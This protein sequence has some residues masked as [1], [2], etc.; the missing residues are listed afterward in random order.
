MDQSGTPAGMKY[1]LAI[2]CSNPSTRG[3][4]RGEV[5]IAKIT[6]DGLDY[7]DSLELSEDARGSDGLMG[8]V[9]VLCL[10]HEIVPTDIAR[11]VVSVGPGGYTALRVSVTVAKVLAT[12]VGCG[13]VA[14]PS[15]AVAGVGLE[16]L[17]A[18]VALASKKGLAHCT[19]IVDGQRTVLGV[20]GADELVGVGAK[21]LVGDGFV[22]KDMI[23]AGEGAGME[24]RTIEL[25]A[26][27][28]LEASV[29]MDEIDPSALG[30]LYA[31][32]PDAVTQW[33][34]LHG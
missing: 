26:R 1:A 16:G 21:V 28:C 29:G 17:D 20:I 7:V 4:S 24:F 8:A 30:V 11:V 12:V 22:P 9:D 18:V 10:K 23:E 34:A 5:A 14:V 3:G 6:D 27:A 13:V 2:E 31:R 15:A 33:R 32:E 25:T 19:R